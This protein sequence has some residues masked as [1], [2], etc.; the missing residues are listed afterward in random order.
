MSDAL[1][2]INGDAN[3]EARPFGVFERQLAMRYLRAKRADGGAALIA[4]IS[5]I[6]IALAAFGLIATMSVMNGFSHVFFSQIIGVQPH[7]FVSVEFA[8]EQE[9]ARLIEEIQ[10]APGVEYAMP[11]VRQTT[12]G[13]RGEISDAVQVIGVRPEDLDH[14]EL[15]AE[16]VLPEA[17]LAEFADPEVNQ[18]FI[19]AGCGVARRFGIVIRTPD[20]E[21]G[22]L[23]ETN[24]RLEIVAPASRSTPFG[25]MPV[26]KAYDVV[27]VFRIGNAEIDR[28]FV[29]MPLEQ[30]Q[31]LLGRGDKVD[32]IAIRVNE[33]LKLP[34]F[35]TVLRDPSEYTNVERGL[36]EATR[37]YYIDSWR[38]QY[39]AYETA[40]RV[41]RT[42]I[43]IILAIV[44][45]ITAMN[46]I[47][48]LVMLSKNKAR[49]IAILRTMGATRVSIMRVFLM[50]G[51]MI[52]VLGTIVG[53]ILGTLFALYI[54]PLQV[55]VERI[56]G[57]SVFDAEVYALSTLPARMEIG[58]VIFVGVWGL[59]MSCIAALPPA[60]NAARLDPV[61]TLRNE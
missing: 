52:G 19:I 50:I 21:C 4:I 8:D 17:A 42:M 32:T 39:S 60:W 15:V 28:Y 10:A 23:P 22:V 58:E 31:V 57:V 29:Y 55:L 36:R 47:S 33:P 38:D 6:G 30:A 7:A 14:L 9:R 61:E 49:D 51:A 40:L 24:R 48:G 25:T 13:K 3:G 26:R 34:R 35:S 56:F 41:E 44:I 16:S 27:G 46:I 45:A 43:R 1:A 59:F 54:E 53:L 11:M 20:T 12:L 2:P 5:F 18:N 37:G